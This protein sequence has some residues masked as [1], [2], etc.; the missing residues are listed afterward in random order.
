MLVVS[1]VQRPALKFLA[2]RMGCVTESGMGIGQSILGDATELH[3][4]SEQ[5]SRIVYQVSL[6]QTPGLL[7]EP[8]GPLQSRTFDPLRSIF[9]VAC[10][11][12]ESRTH[13][14]H[15]LAGQAAKVSGHKLFLFRRAEPPPDAVGLRR[16]HLPLKRSLLGRIKRPKRW[17]KGSRDC[18]ARKPVLQAFRKFQ[19]DSGL[20]S[21]KEVSDSG[22]NR[23]SAHL[24][25]EVGTEN[26]LHRGVPLHASNPYR[27][28][29]VGRHK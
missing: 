23:T 16:F 4:D 1:R 14:N 3:R 18:N 21:V 8:V 2:E 28:H 29:T 9:H 11:D 27:W 20:P 24:Q 15:D 19:C 5:K 10:M 26:A 6:P 12:V 17:G 7:E 13:S 22:V 25:H